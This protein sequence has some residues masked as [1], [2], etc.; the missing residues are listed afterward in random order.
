MYA[1]IINRLLNK[2]LK[3]FYVLTTSQ[4]MNH[5]KCPEYHERALVPKLM[6]IKLSGVFSAKLISV[7]PAKTLLNPPGLGTGKQL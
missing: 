6:C 3:T 4:L 5:Y 1:D 7:T 2:L